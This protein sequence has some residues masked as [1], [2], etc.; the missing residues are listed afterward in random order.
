MTLPPTTAKPVINYRLP[1][2]LA[3]T[4]YDIEISVPFYPYNE[5]DRFFGKVK[6]NFVC[7]NS[8]NQ[9]IF[10]VKD[11][12]LNISSI[13]IEGIND[14]TFQVTSVGWLYDDITNFF[15]ATLQQSFRSGQEYSIY[16]E[17]S[18]LVESN[19][20]GLYKSSYFDENG[21]KRFVSVLLTLVFLY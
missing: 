1:K 19:N 21:R 20:F 12:E 6:L 14:S 17:Y 7:L 13:R 10:H 9:L 2:A 8:T 15:I 3:P 4:H 18:A 11:I 5:P 16:L